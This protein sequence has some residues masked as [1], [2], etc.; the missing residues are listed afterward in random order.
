[1]KGKSLWIM[2]LSFA[3]LSS[4]LVHSYLSALAP[5]EREETVD[6][7]VAARGINANTTISRDMLALK[8][9]PLSQVHPE[10]L[11]NFQE[12]SGRI[13]TSEIVSGEQVLKSRLLPT[14]V[15]PGMSFKIPANRRAMTVAVNEV[16]GVAG[17]VKP[18]D[19][20]DILAT[21]EERTVTVLE[22][23]QVLAIAQNMQ[24]EPKPDARISTSVTLAV[25]PQEAERLTLAEESGRLRLALRPPG[26]T[27]VSSREGV[28]VT[29]IGGTS[30]T[31]TT[32]TSNPS[33]RT[34]EVEQRPIVPSKEQPTVV[35]A[36]RVV[37]SEPQVKE[38]EVEVIRG[39]R[40]E[41]SSVEDSD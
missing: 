12:A 6:V 7:V 20:I 21:F 2:A 41:V 9:V 29:S 17:F 30:A 28:Q 37:P 31:S 39:T 1:M 10:A 27:G 13:A 34:T 40:R 15:T 36:R 4:F 3:L 5:Q 35:Q 38:W 26:A 32:S 16:I 23:I 8:K 18:G 25:T 33:I 24:N 19:R 11:I 22:N 14:G